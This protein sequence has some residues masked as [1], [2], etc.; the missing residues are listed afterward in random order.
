MSTLYITERLTTLLS[1]DRETTR[2]AATSALS[3]LCSRHKYACKILKSLKLVNIPQELLKYHCCYLLLILYPYK[4][5]M[6]YY[7]LSFY[8][9]TKLLSTLACDP[10]SNFSKKR[11][12]AYNGFTWQLRIFSWTWLVCLSFLKF[13]FFLKWLIM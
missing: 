1:N 10:V 7:R 8:F 2:L 9:T 4:K 12:T 5:K 3:L 11:I 13:I 6:L